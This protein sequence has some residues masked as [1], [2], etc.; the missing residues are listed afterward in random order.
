MRSLA[1][2]SPAAPICKKCKHPMRWHIAH[3]S[4]SAKDAAQMNV[5][6]CGE[7]ERY[8]AMPSGRSEDAQ[9]GGLFRFLTTTRGA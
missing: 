5:F 1:S 6:R 8:I 9:V 2:L 3:Q 4:E 7:C